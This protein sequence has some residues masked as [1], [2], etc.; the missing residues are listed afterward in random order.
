[1]STATTPNPTD[2]AAKAKTT[3]IIDMAIDF[4]GMTRVLVTR[5][6]AKIFGKLE[7]LFAELV[8]VSSKER[9][10]QLHLS[11]CDW[12]IQNILTAEK[13]LK[14][15]RIKPVGPC[16]Y[17]HGAK[18]LDITSKV[19]VYYCGL[20]SPERARE[21]VPMLHAAID[22]QILDHLK[23]RFPTA[24]VEATS[25]ADMNRADYELLQSLIATEIREDFNS[26]I[27]RVQYD[28]ILFLRLNRSYE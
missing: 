26:K 15:G 18:V 12:F 17:G 23:R 13:K 19:F 25:I 10:D 4:A 2:L 16:S 9:Y 24:G 20:P 27:Y 8:Q 11:F 7:A 6:N 1:M 5:S 3:M 21:L 14:N 28:D 22:N